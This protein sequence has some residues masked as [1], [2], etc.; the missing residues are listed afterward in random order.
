MLGQIMRQQ[1][2]YYDEGATKRGKPSLRQTTF[3]EKLKGSICILLWICCIPILLIRVF[4]LIFGMRYLAIPEVI[5][6]EILYKAKQIAVNIILALILMLRMSTFATSLTFFD[7]FWG[8][9]IFSFF[10][11]NFNTEEH[12]WYDA[13]L[14]W[15]S[16]FRVTDLV[17]NNEC[18]RVLIPAY[19][20]TLTA[21]CVALLVLEV[22]IRGWIFLAR[23][24]SQCLCPKDRRADL[25]VLKLEA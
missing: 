7:H 2:S 19:L 9:A 4:T 5:H 8:I 23:Q 22:L 1:S 10:A 17:E 3:G 12:A 14:C 6:T 13:R 15:R 11:A 24:I 20:Y 25:Q 18:R 21:L 16:M